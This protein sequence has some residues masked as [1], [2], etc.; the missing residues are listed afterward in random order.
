MQFMRAQ[1]LFELQKIKPK[2]GEKKSNMFLPISG[3]LSR[4]IA[5]NA[6]PNLNIFPLPLFGQINSIIYCPKIACCT[7]DNSC[8]KYLIKTLCTI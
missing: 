2:N 6:W 4:K 8:G 3:R 5:K 1:I 7:R